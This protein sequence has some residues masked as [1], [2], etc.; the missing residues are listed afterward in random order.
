[1]G[2]P[3]AATRT[4]DEAD[5]RRLRLKRTDTDRGWFTEKFLTRMITY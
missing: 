4:S 3:D 5:S 1:M 2:V